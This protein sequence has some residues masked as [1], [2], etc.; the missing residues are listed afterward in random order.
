MC[1]PLIVA[2]VAVAASGAMSA[3]A[4][5]QAGRFEED[6]AKANAQ[7]AEASAASASARGATEAGRLRTEGTELISQQKVALGS[8]GV[9]TSSGTALNLF[10]STRGQVELDAQTARHNAAL[11]AWGH[12]VEKEQYKAQAKIARRNSVLGPLSTI[13]GTAGQ[14]AGMKAMAGK[15]AAKV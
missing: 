11:E 8:N 1:A 14:I 7:L 2:G 4:Q 6:Q 5:Y 12:R 13:I 3:Y 10:A 9:V 15:P